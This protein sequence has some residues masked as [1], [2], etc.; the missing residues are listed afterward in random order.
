[1]KAL[2][3]PGCTLK[4]SGGY[5]E[6]ITSV[7]RVLDITWE[8]IDDW[9][10][11][12]ATAYFS[13]DELVSLVLPARNIAKADGT[14]AQW[15]V[16]PCN[17]CHATLRKAK[18]ILADDLDLREKVKSSLSEEGLF[19]R[20]RVKIKHIL[21]FYLLPEIL[22]KIKSLVVKPLRDF[23]VA[24][25]YGC[26]YTRPVTFDVDDHPENP[27]H[28]DILME[29]LGFT[30]IDFTAKTYCCGAAQM[31]T[32]EEACARLVR[33]I[34]IDAK[35]KGADF[36]VTICPLCHFNLEIAQSKL[37]IESIPVLFFTQAMGIAFGLSEK[38]LGL[39]KL[40]ITPERLLA[41]I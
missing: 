31:V 33:R 36:I 18:E 27:K 15:I 37:D 6:S 28:L 12:G 38:D 14:D 13:L 21:D 34:L 22:D 41:K 4:T 39:K 19:Y 25:Y 17:A 23:K 32:H 26:Q 2:F 30:L 40:L 9:N 7:N 5:E 3:Y 35:N 11:C 29:S 10:C 16:T 8:E 1:M 20:G 24:C